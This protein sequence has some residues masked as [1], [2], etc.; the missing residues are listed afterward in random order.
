MEN[1]SLNRAWGTE[2]EELLFRLLQE[3]LRALPRT[4]P[5]QPPPQVEDEPQQHYEEV[6]MRTQAPQPETVAEQLP[7]QA[8]V[9]PQQN[10]WEVRLRALAPQ[11]QPRIVAEQLPPN[12]Q[13]ESQQHYGRVRLRELAPHWSADE[14][15]ML[16]NWLEAEGN[17]LR[18]CDVTQSPIPN[19]TISAVFRRISEKLNEA[20]VAVA[21]AAASAAAAAALQLLEQAS[22]SPTQE[23]PLEP[24]APEPRT[25]PSTEQLIDEIINTQGGAALAAWLNQPIPREICD[26]AE[27]AYWTIRETRLLRETMSGRHITSWVGIARVFPGKTP[28]QCAVQYHR[29]K[30][31]DLAGGKILHTSLAIKTVIILEAD[32]L[33][34]CQDQPVSGDKLDPFYNFPKS[35]SVMYEYHVIDVCRT[36]N[37]MG[38][39]V[40]F[41]PIISFVYHS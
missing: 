24:P 7:P 2:E 5:E 38:R 23:E 33:N 14:D 35:T 4:V 39:K 41:G 19:R 32:H 6:R 34:P 12:A 30:S 21:A 8:E 9:E 27:G 25:V 13:A 17:D 37:L 31:E 22:I 29:I 40:T 1:Q 28:I 3:S 11:P 16:I 26:A 10:Y 36:M 20:A 18:E 15:Q